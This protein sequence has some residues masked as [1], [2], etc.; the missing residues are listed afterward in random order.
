[1]HLL[2]PGVINLY[3]WLEVPPDVDFAIITTPTFL[4]KE[5]L[6][7]LLIKNIS[8]V[9]EKPIADTLDELDFFAERIKSQ[10]A[11]VYI[12]C[13][14]RFLPVLQFLKIYIETNRQAINEINVYARSYLPAWRPTIDYKKNYSA[15][16]EMG[17]GVHLDLFHE[18]DYTSWIFG[19]PQQ[20]HVV[21]RNVSSL[22]ISAV[23]CA[24]YIWE[25]KI[26]TA[27]TSS[28]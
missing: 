2:I 11:F 18:L 25:Y 24:V 5:A 16:A 14:L 17:G 13:N 28:T 15:N 21:K 6:N 1:M 19:L 27:Y 4:H 26:Y 10:H 8:V 9:I 22:E 7:I 12:A 23:D 20:S 3:D